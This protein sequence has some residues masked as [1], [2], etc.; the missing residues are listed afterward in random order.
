MSH[1]VRGD[2]VDYSDKSRVQDRANWIIEVF[3]TG[4]MPHFEV[5]EAFVQSY[6]AFLDRVAPGQA[7]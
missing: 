1:G 2:F 3:Q 6:D 4:A 5:K 7:K